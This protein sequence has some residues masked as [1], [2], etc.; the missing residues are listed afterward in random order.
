[1]NVIR[2]VAAGY[3]AALFGAWLFYMVRLNG[4][5]QVAMVVGLAL[6]IMSIM[7]AVVALLAY[8]EY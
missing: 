6:F 2:V 7:L 8:D 4:W 5:M 3:L 1:M